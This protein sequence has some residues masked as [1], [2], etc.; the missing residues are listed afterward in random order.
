MTI[1]P[2]LK[3]LI[4]G[5]AA[6]IGCT[7]ALALQEQGARVHLCDA[8]AEQLDRALEQQPALTGSVTDISD[9]AHVERLFED[10]RRSLAKSPAVEAISPDDC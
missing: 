7:T 5:S 2:G 1:Q 8:S 9:A 3:V 10:V 4:A 6:G